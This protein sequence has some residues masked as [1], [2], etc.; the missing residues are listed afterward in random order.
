[1][2]EIPKRIGIGEGGAHVADLAAILNGVVD[3]LAAI[4]TAVVGITAKLDLDAGV[5]DTDYAA[6]QN[7]PA[8]VTTKEA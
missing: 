8:L 3:D 2:A 6:T 4:R 5:T 7:P 1:M